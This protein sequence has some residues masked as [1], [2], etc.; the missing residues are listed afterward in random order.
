MTY[1]GYINPGL[2]A[3]LMFEHSLEQGLKHRNAKSFAPFTVAK[4]PRLEDHID[5]PIF[6]A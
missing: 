6:L 2:L 3:K 1:R 4:L 5:G